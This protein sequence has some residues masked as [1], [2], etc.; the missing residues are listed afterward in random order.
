MNQ[1]TKC[2]C[3]AYSLPKKN[4]HSDLITL[5]NRKH[6]QRNSDDCFKVLTKT[7]KPF[8]QQFY[9]ERRQSKLE[10]K[11]SRSVKLSSQF[12]VPRNAM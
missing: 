9:L 1:D 6:K 5:A 10:Y 4:L 12:E 8:E 7:K 3:S 11:L 2:S